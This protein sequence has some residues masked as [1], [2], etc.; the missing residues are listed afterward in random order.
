MKSSVFRNILM[1]KERKI[2]INSHAKQRLSERNMRETIFMEEINKS[3]PTLSIEQDYDNPSIRK[4]RL[5]FLQT[6]NY[7]HT[8]IITINSE[9][10]L[11]SAW[12]PSKIKQKDLY[13][14]KFHIK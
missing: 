10:R 12:R 14:G 4:F 11:L 8:Y 3:I 13:Q 7:Y 9:I 6:K 2:M 1:S 5:Y